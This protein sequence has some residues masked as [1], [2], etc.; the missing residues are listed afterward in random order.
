MFIFVSGASNYAVTAHGKYC[1]DTGK[2]AIVDEHEC[3]QAAKLLG[4]TYKRAE[5]NANSPR[6]CYFDGNGN[7]FWN[8]HKTGSKP[9]NGASICLKIGSDF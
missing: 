4:K 5:E 8:R 6:G 9:S 3:I 2:V 1:T 7:A